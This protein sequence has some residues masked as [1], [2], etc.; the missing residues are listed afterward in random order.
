[1]EKAVGLLDGVVARYPEQDLFRLTVL[2][3]ASLAGDPQKSTR[4]KSQ[5]QAVIDKYGAQAYYDEY[6][7]PLINV[8]GQAK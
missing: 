8:L 2:E 1:M 6:I 4:Y 3:K 5:K 7:L